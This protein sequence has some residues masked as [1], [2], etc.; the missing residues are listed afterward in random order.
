MKNRKAKNAAVRLKGRQQA[1]AK[2]PAHE[3]HTPGSMNPHKGGPATPR[4]R[5]RR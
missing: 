4:K 5:K 3:H 2:N 1:V